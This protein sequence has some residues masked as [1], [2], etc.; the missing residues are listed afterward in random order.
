MIYF[1]SGLANISQDLYDAAAIDGANGI[2]RFFY[3]T[4]PQLRPIII[5]VMTLT[6]IGGFQLFVEPFIL[7]NAGHCPFSLS[8]RFYLIQLGLRLD[9]WGG[10]GF[11]YY[12]SLPGTT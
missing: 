5:F 9:H 12:G 4:V 7:W 11:D 6:L 3:I 8:N 2:Q 1:T 10:V